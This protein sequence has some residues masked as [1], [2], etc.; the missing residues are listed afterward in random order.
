MT[1]Y[2]DD[3]LIL[4]GCGLITYSAWLLSH[5]LAFF[6]AGG[7]CILGGVIVALSNRSNG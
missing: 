1:K 6:V 4:I 7:F 2:L 5:V 3:L